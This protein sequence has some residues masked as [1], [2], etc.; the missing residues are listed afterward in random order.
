MF[1]LDSCIHHENMI[2]EFDFNNDCFLNCRESG[3]KGGD[4]L[5]DGLAKSR[6]T[7]CY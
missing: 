1:D 2:Q 6:Q 4:F 5:D 7:N 3:A